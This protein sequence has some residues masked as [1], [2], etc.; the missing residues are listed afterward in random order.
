MQRFPLQ[1]ARLPQASPISHVPCLRLISSVCPSHNE[2]LPF[3]F[4]P[5]ISA[6]IPDRLI[7]L[8]VALFVRGAHCQYVFAWRLR[9]PLSFP[10]PERISSMILTELRLSPALRAVLGKLNLHDFSMA[11]EGNPAQRNV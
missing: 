11:A 5:Q 9:R 8:H 7:R 4:V 3:N 2:V 1:Q 6:R 10:V